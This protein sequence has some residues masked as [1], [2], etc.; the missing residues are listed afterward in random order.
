MK[1]VKEKSK[2]AFEPFVLSFFLV[3]SGLVR[4]ITHGEEN[5]APQYLIPVQTKKG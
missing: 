5:Q 1:R 3:T 2:H 4:K